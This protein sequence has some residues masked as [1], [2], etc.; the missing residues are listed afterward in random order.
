MVNN[1]E[2]LSPKAETLVVHQ[3]CLMNTQF[4]MD[5]TWWIVLSNYALNYDVVLLMT[6]F[7][8]ENATVRFLNT[9]T[10]VS[11]WRTESL[12]YINSKYCL[13]RALEKFCLYIFLLIALFSSNIKWVFALPHQNAM[14]FTNYLWP[15]IST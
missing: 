4:I 13:G 15:F 7:A 14:Y 6:T 10:N 2:I 11:N 12:Y 5:I 8:P 9:T 1:W 3:S